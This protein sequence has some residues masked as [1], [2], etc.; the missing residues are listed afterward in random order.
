MKKG[1]LCADLHVRILSLVH[2]HKRGSCSLCATQSSR[3]V[4][5]VAPQG[6]PFF[7]TFRTCRVATRPF[8][9]GKRNP[10]SSTQVRAGSPDTPLLSKRSS[11]RTAD[12]RYTPLAALQP[13]RPGTFQTTSSMYVAAAEFRSSLSRGNPALSLFTF[14]PPCLIIAYF[15]RQRSRNRARPVLQAL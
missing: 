5:V 8:R 9:R 6:F 1:G 3:S 11:R 15:R 13:A 4:M 12:P 7:L 14:P 10:N 2:K